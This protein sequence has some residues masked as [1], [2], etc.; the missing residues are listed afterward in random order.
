MSCSVCYDVAV[1]HQGRCPSCG[2]G[3]THVWA[4]GRGSMYTYLVSNSVALIAVLAMW[5][6]W[7][8]STST[9]I[10]WLFFFVL[11]LYAGYRLALGIADMFVGRRLYRGMVTD[12]SAAR[13]MDMFAGSDLRLRIDQ[14]RFKLEDIALRQLK[15]GEEVLVLHTPGTRTITSL[16]RVTEEAEP[17]EEPPPRQRRGRT[18]RERR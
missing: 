12:I 10:A 1:A 18:R 6:F 3:Y 15:K 5:A 9:M 14:R 16:Y 4:G 11:S 17:Q 13:L 7:G 2:A 8:A